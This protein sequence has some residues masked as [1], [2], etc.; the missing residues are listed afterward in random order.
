MKV[1]DYKRVI[2]DKIEMLNIRIDIYKEILSEVEKLQAH[3][4][5]EY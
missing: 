4:V 2:E 3:N 5:N 1:D